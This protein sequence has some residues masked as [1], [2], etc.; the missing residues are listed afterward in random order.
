MTVNFT[1]AEVME[2]RPDGSPIAVQGGR[3]SE[4]AFPFINC[5]KMRPK[6]LTGK[7]RGFLP[8]VNWWRFQ[9]IAFFGEAGGRVADSYAEGMRP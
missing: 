9:V 2:E 6:R 1:S 8:P 4:N 7:C 3:S 5:G